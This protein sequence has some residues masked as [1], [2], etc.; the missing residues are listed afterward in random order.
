MM[1]TTSSAGPP[2]TECPPCVNRKTKQTWPCGSTWKE[3]CNN[4]T[5]AGGVLQLSPV[6]CPEYSHP[7]C[8]RGL[9]VNVSDGCCERP[10]CDCR[11][12]L[13]GDPHY[14]SFQG[15]TFDF[16]DACT[17][18]LVEEQSPQY[19]LTIAVDNFYCIPGL[20]ASCVKGVIV[21]YKGNTATLTIDSLTVQASLNNVLIPVPFEE[22]G[23]RFESTGYVTT[24]VLPEIRSYVSLTP[25]FSLIV[26]LAME[27]F[28]NNTQ[29]QCGV[30]GGGSCIR[31]GGHIENDKCCDKTAYD[32]VYE[33]PQ[34]PK[35]ASAPKNL[36]CDSPTPSPTPCINSKCELLR[37]PLF[38]ECR[39][40]V[41]LSL[42]IKNCEFDSCGS[43][44]P[45]SSWR[46]LQTSVKNMVSVLSGESTLMEV[47]AQSVQ[48]D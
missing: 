22:F 11:C 12:E 46:K 10:F 23:M 32:W 13:Y 7:N 21:K 48:K 45:C 20:E 1:P 31:R 3:D 43:A 5:C 41:D 9:A 26:N 27:N 28:V 42:I 47:A 8:P 38:A 36:P 34:K 2:P 16:F 17:Y 33:D 29:G 24:L 40:N 4:V 30:C 44:F 6:P 25:R 15:V 18:V 14:I 35:C 37:Q 19:N 39:D